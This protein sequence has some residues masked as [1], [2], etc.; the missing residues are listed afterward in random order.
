MRLRNRKN[1]IFTVS[2]ILLII[3]AILLWPGET[4]L[5]TNL[6]VPVI[7]DSLPPG[8]TFSSP[9]E[10][11]FEIRVRGPQHL[12]EHLPEKN[13]TYRLDLS[14][15]AAGVQS[16]RID[17]DRISLPGA[18]E[19]IRVTPTYILTRLEKELEKRVPVSVS[20]SG[21]PASGFYV[22]DT[23]SKPKWVVLR[24]PES[25]LD[26][27]DKMVTKAIDVSGMSE[28][29]K[30]ETTLDLVEGLTEISTQGI[31]LA[32]IFM[33]EKV[34]TRKFENIAVR[35]TGCAYR[36][37]ISPAVISIDVKGP[38]TAIEKLSAQKG[39]TVHVDL[40]S[41]EPGVYVRCASISLPNETTL[42][43]VDPE[44]FTVKIWDTK[45]SGKL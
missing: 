3:G 26:P 28:S 1:I 40:T 6:F 34:V 2:C 29:F 39:I 30:K 37:K 32:K 36:H 16:T 12:V 10:K 41:L 14:E 9:M 8:L 33:E 45:G 21:K 35:G 11:G 18:I 44:I 5:E 25:I 27:I 19:I 42:I 31:I 20:V 38:V 22:S 13:L 17:P 23:V 43:G 15:T 7:A 4:M 24:G